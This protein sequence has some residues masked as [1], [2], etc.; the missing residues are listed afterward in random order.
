MEQNFSTEPRKTK[1]GKIGTVIG[2]IA[3]V[4]IVGGGAGFGGATLASGIINIGNSIFTDDGGE[5]NDTDN[6]KDDGSSDNKDDGSSDNK[7]D[8]SS[9]LNAITD[10]YGDG[11]SDKTYPSDVT[12]TGPNGEY[13]TSELYDAVNDTVVLIKVYSESALGSYDN[14]YDYYF[15]YDSEYIEPDDG[16]NLVYTGYGSGIIFTEDGYILTNEHVVRDAAKVEVIVNDYYDSEVTH[17]YVAEV[18][19]SDKPSDIAVIKISRDEKFI[20]AKLG[21]SDT[22]NVGQDVCAI[23]NPGV[24]ATIMFDHTLTKGII[25]GLNRLCLSE[26]YNLSL[27]QTDAAINSG[28]SGGGL[29]DMYGNIIGI[30][31]SKIVADT[32]EGLGFALTINE[33][34][35]IMEDLLNYGYVKSR[36]VLGIETLELNAQRAQSKGLKITK[37]LY[38][39]SINNDAPVAK[40]GLKVGDVI[41][42]INGTNVETV[43]DVQT[44]L[45]KFKV[46][47]KVTATVARPVS[48]GKLESVEITIELSESSQ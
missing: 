32:Y 36:P 23:G 12:P 47:D 28:N 46:G 31:N 21:N 40:S 25:S 18:L 30:V 48:G 42:K 27:I 2:L 16:D 37:G 35:P 34:K 7:G 14:Y 22:L 1:S 41:T 26:G 19:G 4:I 29:F 10:S 17:T 6:K 11:S 44:I 20:P 9:A 33:A 15:G 8:V 5:K 45:S 13:T 43:S 39:S 38:V 24:T 3:A